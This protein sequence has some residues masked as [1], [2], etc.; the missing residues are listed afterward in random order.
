MLFILNSY[1]F[2]SFQLP[3]TSEISFNLFDLFFSVYALKRG[4]YNT[5]REKKAQNI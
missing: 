3:L 1:Y 5:I 4:K 2:F